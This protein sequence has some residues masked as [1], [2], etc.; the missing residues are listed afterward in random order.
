MGEAQQL[1]TRWRDLNNMAK[2]HVTVDRQIGRLRV[3]MARFVGEIAEPL[4][5]G[6]ARC[7]YC[8]TLEGYVGLFLRE[9]HLVLEGLDLISEYT[10]EE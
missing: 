7:G 1:G 10:K 6:P 8:A 9:V 3:A 2:A 5:H 4:A